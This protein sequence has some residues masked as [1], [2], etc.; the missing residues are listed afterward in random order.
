[1]KQ[2]LYLGT[3]PT[4]FIDENAT[5]VHV[6]LIQIVPND[7]HGF[8]I[9]KQ[10]EDLKEYTHFLLT[11]K[12]AVHIFMQAVKSCGALLEILQDKMFLAI[13]PSTSEALRQYGILNISLP[14]VAT[15][16]GMMDLLD[17]LDCTNAYFF[18]PRSAKARPVLSYYLRVRKLRHQVCALYDT[19]DQTAQVLPP[20][21]QF[22]EIIFTSPSTVEAFYRI[23]Q[24]IPEHILIKSIGPITKAA[25]DKYFLNR[26]I[27]IFT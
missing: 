23:C 27:Q 15:Q 13:G 22:H 25:L 19:L 12:H 24:H 3:D 11:S 5:V 1:M 10:L 18:Y 9:Q 26:T 14:K 6:P 7:V 4:Q 8:K 17:A 20:L 16:E 2:V 21:E